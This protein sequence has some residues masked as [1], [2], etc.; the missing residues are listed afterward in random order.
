MNLRRRLKKRLELSV[1]LGCVLGVSI[2]VL[3][4]F[5]QGFLSAGHF[6][7]IA[8]FA[9]SMSLVLTVVLLLVPRA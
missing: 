3:V 6:G 9:L 2:A 8:F 7:L 5:L 1:T 4:S